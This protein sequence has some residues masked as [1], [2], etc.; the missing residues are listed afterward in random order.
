MTVPV[1]TEG[2]DW[3]H[4]QGAVD[5]DTM[6]DRWL[7]E[8]LFFKATEGTTFFDGRFK[9]NWTQSRWKAENSLIVRGPYHFAR[10]LNDPEKSAEVF[11]NFVDDCGGWLPE[12]IPVMDAEVSDGVGQTVYNQ[13]LK[14]WAAHVLKLRG[15]APWL[16][17]GSAY[18]ENRTGEGLNGPYAGWW[19]PRY[20]TAWANKALFPTE[21]NPTLPS[22][23]AWGGLPD[24]W[25]FSATFPAGQP[26][27]ANVSR[28]T[29][30]SLRTVTRMDEPMLDLRKGDTGLEVKTLQTFLRVLGY[31]EVVVDGVYGTTTSAAVLK[32]RKAQGSA[33]TSGDWIDNWAYQQLFTAFSKKYAGVDGV[34]GQDGAPGPAGPPGPM[35]PAGN[36]GQTPLAGTFDVTEYKP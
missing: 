32:M 17:T 30:T 8:H 21:F 15:R 27:D 36:D 6:V 24:I 16:Y 33:A 14:A 23:N 5:V 26:F 28:R 35:G 4:H 1:Q 29:L 7:V 13:W 31:T 2:F 12:D 18:M 20:P 22:P 10:P 19:Y 9:S 3:S 11:L 34:D 25:Q